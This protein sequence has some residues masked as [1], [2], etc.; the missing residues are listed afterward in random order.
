MRLRPEI[1]EASAYRQG[2]LAGPSAFKLSS[3]ENPFYP[4]PSVLATYA[5]VVALNRY[6]DTSARELRTAIA[7]KHNGT[8]HNGGSINSLTLDNV[9]VG[10]GSLAVLQN[11]LAC[12]ASRGD[13]IIYAWRSFEGYPSSVRAIGATA[14]EV[15]LTPAFDHDLDAMQAAITSATRAIILCTPNNPTG[16]VLSQAQVEAFVEAVPDDILIIID[17]AYFEFAH[18]DLDSL[19]IVAKHDNVAVLRTFSK[20]YGLAGLRVGYV[21]AAPE[22]VEA[23]A[24]ETIAFSVTAATQAAAVESL[25][26]QDELDAR[27]AELTERRD[28]LVHGLKAQGWEFPDPHGNFVWLP[29]GEATTAA[30]QIFNEHDLIVRAFAGEGIRV[31]IGEAESIEPLLNAAAIIVATIGGTAKKAQ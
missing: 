3:N 1:A 13:E 31:T 21:I 26:V 11:L 20:A 25:R 12:V 6:P 23:L 16:N 5:A 29:L 17:E 2:K 8:E 15:P 10:A 24:V 14:V 18:G 9:G 7:A 27:I 19:S 4:L 30:E 28:Q 22:L